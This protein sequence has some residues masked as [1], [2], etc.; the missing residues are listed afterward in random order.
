MTPVTE[1]FSNRVENYIRYRPHYPPGVIECLRSNCGMTEVSVIADVGS[2]TGILTELFL[3]NGNIVFGVEPNREMRAA[4]ERLLQHSPRFRSIVGTAEETTLASSSVDFVTVGQAFHW[5]DQD[6]AR[7]E[8]QRILKPQGWVALIWNERLEEST[9]FS[10]D[11]EQL[12]RTFAT[13]YEAV[14]H[15]RIDQAI[16]RKFFAGDFGTC[17]FENSQQFDF[18]GLKGR[19]LSSSY[20]P[21]AGNPQHV[22]MLVELRRLFGAHQIN[23]QVTF[24]YDANLYYGSLT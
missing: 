13:D 22:P 12:L 20:A 21:E 1:R 5:F 16:L 19:L 15:K 18:E 4:G 3:K 11:Y 24:E 23:N 7:A 6:R 10:H 17:T 9:P 8:F 14:N 2:G